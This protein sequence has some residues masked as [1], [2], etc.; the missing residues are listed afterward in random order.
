MNNGTN[1]ILHIGII[2]AGRGGWSLLRVLEH[3]PKIQVV[4]ICDLN[5]HAPALE[6]ARQHNIPVY[7]NVAELI[8]S[9]EMDWLIN[10]SAESVTAGHLFERDLEGRSV[11]VMDGASAEV[12]WRFLVNFHQLVE[13]CPQQERSCCHEL[14]WAFI[15]AIADSV[16]EVQR[17]LTDI[18]FNDPLTGLFTRRIMLE[19]LQREIRTTYRL[20]HPLSL[21]LVDVDRFKSVNDQFGHAAGDEILKELANLMRTSHRPTD[22]VARMGGEEFVTVLPETNLTDAVQIAERLRGQVE[23]EVQ[24]PDGTPLTVSVGVSTLNV[25]DPVAKR[26]NPNALLECADQAL[27]QAK[28][29]GRNRVVAFQSQWDRISQ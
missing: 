19:F 3:L 21:L 9:Q 15:S 16:K 10:V 2:G 20:S 12:V 24:R 4:G 5:P 26:M 7:D 28:N 14:A 6:M 8:A 25:G 1:A 23:R 29:S 27:Y 11:N 18:A 17:R 22:L 13:H